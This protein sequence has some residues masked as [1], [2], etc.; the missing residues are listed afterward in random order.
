MKKR[1]FMISLFLLFVLAVLISH[2][3]FVPSTFIKH[4]FKNMKLDDI[5]SVRIGA[6]YD[7]EK[8]YELSKEETE[9]LFE[10]LKKIKLSKRMNFKWNE[11]ESPIYINEEGGISSEILITLKSGKTINLSA[12]NKTIMSEQREVY[13]YRHYVINYVNFEISDKE[14]ELLN[15]FIAFC[16]EIVDEK[17]LQK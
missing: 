3:Y 8:T 1:I 6:Y 4:P 16:D 14:E 15:T 7:G 5:E 9:T 10:I 2:I 13:K 12:H 17:L 11:R